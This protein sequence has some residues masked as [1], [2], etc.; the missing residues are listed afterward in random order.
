MMT[1]Q[2]DDYISLGGRV[3]TQHTFLHWGIHPSMYYITRFFRARV[4]WVGGGK[5]GEAYPS[6]HWA[7]Y[8]GN[9]TLQ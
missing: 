2:T 7:K 4:A 5:G 1:K 3:D 6:M 8:I 9:H